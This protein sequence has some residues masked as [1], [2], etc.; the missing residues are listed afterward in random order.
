MGIFYTK[1][2]DDGYTGIIG[3]RRVPKF[4]VRVEALGAVDEANAALGLSRSATRSE[5][6]AAFLLKVQRD[7]Y[8]LMAEVAME[9]EESIALLRQRITPETVT[10]LEKEIDRVNA[11]VTMPEGFIVP[12]DCTSGAY[13]DLARTT[14]RRAERRI[15]ELYYLGQV[16][17]PALIRYLNRLSSLCFVLE[18]Y[19]NTLCGGNPV[20]MN[21]V[22]QS[23]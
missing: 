8:L 16:Q 12:G 17:N 5:Q 11:L 6:T 2:G 9:D 19:E 23:Q 4:D 3:D 13:L 22:D 20:T 15:S 18:I 10:D 1:T 21:K 14:V 7:L